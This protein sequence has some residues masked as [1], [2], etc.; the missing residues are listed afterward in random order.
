MKL[1]TLYKKTTTGAIQ[2]W[3]IAVNP[4]KTG[5]AAIVTSYGQ[6]GGKIQETV[7]WIT[8]GKNIGKANETTPQQQ[9]EAEAQS[10]WEK[11]LKKGYVQTV[12]DAVKGKVDDVIEGGIFPMLAHRF[13]EQ[14]HKIVYPAYAQPK[15]DGHRCIA[16]IEDGEVTLWSRTRKPITGLPHIVKELKELS[17]RMNIFNFVLDGELYNHDYR[18]SFEELTSF[19][20]NPEP[21][22]GHE[23][24]Q[25]HVYD[26]PSCP[27]GFGDR[28]AAL[29]KLFDRIYMWTPNRY[30]VPVETVR[31][32][33]EDDVMLAFERFLAQGYEGAMVRNADGLYVNKR[34]YDLQKVKEFEDAE[35]EVADVKEGRGKM[36]GHAIFICKTNPNDQRM[37][38]NATFDAKMKGKL[39]DLKKYWDNPEL[40]IK[41]LLT[42]KFQ[43]VTKKNR[44]PRF[45]VA[46][47]FKEEL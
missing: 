33:D 12:T 15:F 32:E 11:K 46:L 25:Y 19:I 31:V 17:V 24:V 18:A 29:D 38:P 34:S 20:R 16:V 35:F 3:D 26:M 44:V 1:K 2:Q 41:K 7:D 43:G 5:K 6:V 47:R 4:S 45:P 13:D 22:D 37:D 23:A 21:K 10:Q 39:E 42:V 8:E 27:G 30:L 14:G 28:A 40:A 9:A 36:A